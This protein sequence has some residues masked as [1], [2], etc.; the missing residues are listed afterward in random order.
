M[1]A[2]TD[3]EDFECMDLDGEGAVIEA[4]SPT[5][6]SPRHLMMCSSTSRAAKARVKPGSHAHIFHPVSKLGIY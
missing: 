1:K 5:M 4:L 3:D 6:E 2:K